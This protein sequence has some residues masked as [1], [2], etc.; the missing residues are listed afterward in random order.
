MDA[1]G[2]APA[3]GWRLGA[4]RGGYVG[5]Y[6]NPLGGEEPMS[7]VLLGGVAMYA[8]A[9]LVMLA[10]VVWDLGKPGTLKLLWRERDDEQ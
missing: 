2:S 5:G 10:M 4:L 1:V 9:V 6:A 7:L 3:G 8:A